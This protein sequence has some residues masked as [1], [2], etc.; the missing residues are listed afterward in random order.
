MTNEPPEC[1]TC[2]SDYNL[3]DPGEPYESGNCDKCE[4]EMLCADLRKS[5]L[6]VDEVRKAV[7]Y[8]ANPD[9][10]MHDVGAYRRYARGVL[11]RF[12][13]DKRIDLPPRLDGPEP[14]LSKEDQAALDALHCKR[15]GLPG[16]RCIF[17]TPAS[18]STC[19][20]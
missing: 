7:E 10:S 20:H 8:M 15:C 6:Q 16:L 3:P 17:C 19:G 14:T 11:E 1:S 12:F 5:D 4:I 13:T 2:G 18:S 9:G